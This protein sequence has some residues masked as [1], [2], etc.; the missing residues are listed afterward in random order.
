MKTVIEDIIN[1][2]YPDTIFK[3]KNFDESPIFGMDSKNEF[4]VESYLFEFSFNEQIVLPM[5]KLEIENDLTKLTGW[6]YIINL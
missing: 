2:L 5:T 1:L 4:V 6:E 3:I